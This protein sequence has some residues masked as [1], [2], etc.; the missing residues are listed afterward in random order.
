MERPQPK[1]P[2]CQAFSPWVQRQNSS[3]FSFSYQENLYGKYG[4]ICLCGPQNKRAQPRCSES[5]A[6]PEMPANMFT[7]PRIASRSSP[8]FRTSRSPPATSPSLDPSTPRS[9]LRALRS[10]G[11]GDASLRIDSSA[12]RA[13]PRANLRPLS[14]SANADFSSISLISR[15]ERCFLFSLPVP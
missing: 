5:L 14:L 1:K 10:R 8:T 13:A 7:A 12:V 11:P 2:F 4:V 3:F 6:H 15:T 9:A